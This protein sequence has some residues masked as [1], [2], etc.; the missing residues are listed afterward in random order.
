V[1][2]V[3]KPGRNTLVCCINNESITEL[4]TG[5]IM[6]PVLLYRPRHAERN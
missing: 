6:R 5:G 4:E 3:L 2:G 1:T